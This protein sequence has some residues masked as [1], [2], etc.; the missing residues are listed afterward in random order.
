M[1]TTVDYNKIYEALENYS[2]RVLTA[3]SLAYKIGVERIYG[4]TMSKLVRDGY[5]IKANCKGYY[6]IASKHN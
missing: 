2:G 1:T 5:L 6:Y 4:G 3:S